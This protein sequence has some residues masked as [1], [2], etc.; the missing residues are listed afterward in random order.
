MKTQI[1][2]ISTRVLVWI[3]LLACGLAGVPRI[4]AAMVL[5]PATASATPPAF[6]IQDASAKLI[7]VKPNGAEEFSFTFTLRNAESQPVFI[8]DQSVFLA[9]EGG[10]SRS[11]GAN[12]I[13]NMVGS[14]TI[15]ANSEST[16]SYQSPSAGERTAK[17]VIVRL[18][19]AIKGYDITKT[20]FCQ[21]PIV[22]PS[23]PAPATL[24]Y[25][26]VDTPVYIGL[27][28]P[29]ETFTISTFKEWLQIAG[30]IVN[31]TK[32][33]ATLN[34]YKIT[35]S[36]KQAGAPATSVVETMT[37]GPDAFDGANKINPFFFGKEMNF[38]DP[39]PFVVKIEANLT[40]AGTNY[41]IARVVSVEPNQGPTH[42]APVWG[43]W[44]WGNGPGRYDFHSHYRN[45]D[46]RYAYD[47]GMFGTNDNGAVSLTNGDLG[48]NYSYFCFNEL[49]YAIADGTVTSVVSNFP[50]N[51]GNIPT[52]GTGNNWV[53]VQ[54]GD[55]ANPYFSL[56][57]HIRQYSAFVEVGDKVSAGDPLARVG[58]AGSTGGA[59][60][61]HLSVYDLDKTGHIRARPIHFA[62]PSFG[63]VPIGT[64]GITGH[65][66]P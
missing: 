16:V 55:P 22:N 38:G 9:S 27:Q 5:G 42:S 19:V 48:Q 15:P 46:Q 40:I 17:H 62:A 14:T 43:H 7:S 33:A 63:T 47:L 2:S 50:D 6:Y 57:V 39:M 11:M 20:V 54:H 65:I 31:L 35:I 60:H 18:K 37:F 66:T 30:Q 25:L 26:S 4:G 58:N 41:N 21:I 44:N 51:N 52:P 34:S 28:Q 61:L 8:V 36:Y 56:Y 13:S 45:E 12:W 3:L 49:I 32:E 53:V 10:W 29:L 64:D 1:R 24:P 59:P 23:L